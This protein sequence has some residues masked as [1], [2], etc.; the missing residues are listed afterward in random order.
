MTPGF[1]YSISLSANYSDFVASATYFRIEAIELPPTI[2]VTGNSVPV[3][4]S[5]AVILSGS[6]TENNSPKALSFLWECISVQ[7]PAPPNELEDPSSCSFDLSI[8]RSAREETLI[9][10]RNYLDPDAS[11]IFKLIVSNSSELTSTATFA[12]QTIADTALTIQLSS[13]NTKTSPAYISPDD[14]ARILMSVPAPPFSGL[15]FSWTVETGKYSRGQI[16][17]SDFSKVLTSTSSPYLVL[18]ENV[19]QPNKNYTFKLNVIASN[20][21]LGFARFRVIVLEGRPLP[22]TSP[23][24]SLPSAD[25]QAQAPHAADSARYPRAAESP[26]K[27]RSA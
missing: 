6:N 11:Y 19:L 7:S 3:D 9:L 18:R 25:P 24:P 23:P 16:A 2:R 1:N 15:S 21:S 12:L 10:P 4:A 14:K 26:S 13:V 8:L 5:K 22:F 27:R 17:L 20:G